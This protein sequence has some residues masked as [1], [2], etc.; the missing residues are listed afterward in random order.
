MKKKTIIGILLA[1]IVV[2]PSVSAS[3]IAENVKLNVGSDGSHV[4]V[5]P[6]LI[7][8]DIDK[9]Y[10][11]PY[12]S[13]YYCLV[14]NIGNTESEDII[15]VEV[16]V[17]EEWL[18]F[19]LIPMTEIH[20]FRAGDNYAP[21]LLP[22]ESIGIVFAFSDKFHAGSTLKFSAEVNPE[23]TIEELDYNNNFYEEEMSKPVV[24]LNSAATQTTPEI[25]QE[26]ELLDQLSELEEQYFKT[27]AEIQH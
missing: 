14:R 25:I 27:E 10:E 2:I 15:I 13:E 24:V 17:I 6:D 4:I 22:G 16:E 3:N 20:N 19:G 26:S 12:L 11:N 5:L 9:I 8:E 23:H 7:I 18:L 1:L 21:F